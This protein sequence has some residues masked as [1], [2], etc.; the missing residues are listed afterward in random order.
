[1][2]LSFESQ[3]LSLAFWQI[4]NIQN[5]LNE[6]LALPVPTYIWQLPLEY[7]DTEKIS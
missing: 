2:R 6:L 1:M 5:M 7:F 4:G 3:L